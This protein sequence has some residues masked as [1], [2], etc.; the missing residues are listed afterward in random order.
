MA[1][2]LFDTTTALEPLRAQ[3]D[4][5]IADVVAARQFILGPQVTAFEQ[6]FARHCGAR[7]AVGVANGTD[8]RTTALRATGAGPGDDVIVPS[9]TFYATAEAVPATGARPV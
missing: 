7:H 5:A 3:I 2:P 1:V 4:A 9:F 8:A 6:E